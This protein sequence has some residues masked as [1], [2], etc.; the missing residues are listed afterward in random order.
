MKQK[1]ITL[2]LLAFALMFTLVFSTFESVN[3][4]TKSTTISKKLEYQKPLDISIGKGGVYFPSSGYT[5]KVVLT[6][7]IPVDTKKLTF[8]QRWIDIRLYDTNGKEIKAV[9]GYTYVYFNLNVEDRAAW[10]NEKLSIYHYNEAKKVWEE[11]ATRLLDTKSAPY[12][13]VSFMVTDQYGLYGL[14]IKK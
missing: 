2:V 6:R 9:K 4:Q 3:A 14:A 11:C 13:R 10:R 5:G 1:R 8:T 12:G 7:T